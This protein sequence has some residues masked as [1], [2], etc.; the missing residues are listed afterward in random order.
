MSV[1]LPPDKLGDI[2][3]LALSL[4]RNQYVTVCRAMS[5]LGKANFVPMATPNCGTF[6]MSFKVT[7]YMSTILPPIYLL[8]FIFSRSSLCQLEQLSH[9]EQS[10]VPL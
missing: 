4:L 6:V 1:S 7:C 3:Q 8:R 2:Q 9:F 5:F 10:P